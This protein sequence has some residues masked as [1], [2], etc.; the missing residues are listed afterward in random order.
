M[1]SGLR[2]NASLAVNTLSRQGVR[3]LYHWVREREALRLKHR[4]DMQPHLLAR[5]NLAASRRGS[6]LGAVLHAGGCDDVRRLTAAA[7]ERRP[8]LIGALRSLPLQDAIDLYT[9][10]RY[11]DDFRTSSF[12]RTA[13]LQAHLRE[14][15][16]A[17]DLMPDSL[18]AALE[19]GSPDVV[20]QLASSKR[21]R[22]QGKGQDQVARTV[23]TA[24]ALRGEAEA[25]AR[26]WMQALQPRDF[27]FREYLRAKTV[28][29][30][31]P[32]AKLEEV[33]DEIDSFDVIVRPNYQ[34]GVDPS[35]GSR[36]DVSY[37]NGYRLESRR[38]EIM[39]AA[40]ELPWLV[41]ARGS[42]Q[43]LRS[44]FPMHMGI[45]SAEHTGPD[46]TC[47]V[48]LAIPI[49]LADLIRF[50]P[51]RIKLFQVDFFR[52]A[53]AYRKGYH[54]RPI[55]SDAIAHSL[56]VHDPFSSFRFVQE[57]HRAGLCEAD[58]V[59][60]EVLELSLEEYAAC[61]QELYGHHMVENE[62]PQLKGVPK[63]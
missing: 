42:D 45:R 46:F 35:H 39:A 32:A 40:S 26:I 11:F 29:V 19:L 3:A 34:G 7:V 43:A 18:A 51:A 47:A 14:Q 31:G 63:R 20:L 27:A 6:A 50:S 24:H 55:G 2:R 57:L 49:M 48:P 59:A 22:S 15:E 53:A 8:N 1:L 4:R 23:A 54:R 33:G 9:Y 60:G 38:D 56:R 58:D 17:N 13:M 37:Y 36:T 30:V 16:G 61:M 28:A 41:A 62:N 25:A 5:L 10:Y 12:L 52:S 21:A 44:M